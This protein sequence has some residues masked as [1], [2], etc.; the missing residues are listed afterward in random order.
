MFWSTSVDAGYD[1]VWSGELF[2]KFLH[3][4]E[5]IRILSVFLPLFLD[6]GPSLS[7]KW[8]NSARLNTRNISNNLHQ[9]CKIDLSHKFY[10]TRRLKERKRFEGSTTLKVYLPRRGTFGYHS[11]YSLT[12]AVLTCIRAKHVCVFFI[13]IN[14]RHKCRNKRKITNCQLGQ[15]ANWQSRDFQIHSS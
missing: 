2:E 3:R 1:D 6:S 4:L 7:R 10:F 8:T 15:F 13:W 9:F 14:Y 5:I 11:S 12:E